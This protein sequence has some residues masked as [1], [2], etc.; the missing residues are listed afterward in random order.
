MQSVKEDTARTDDVHT[1][2]QVLGIAMREVRAV[3]YAVGV[4][5]IIAAAALVKG[6]YSS[7][8]EALL[9]GAAMLILMV[10]LLV[11]ERA[12]RVPPRFLQPHALVFTSAILT[13]FIVA[14]F[15]S[16]SIVFFEW[17]KRVSD[18]L[19]QIRGEN[20]VSVES[21]SD[22]SQVRKDADNAMKRKD[23]R[24]ALVLYRKL[25]DTGNSWAWFQLGWMYN[26]GFGVARDEAQALYWYRK[27]AAV[28]EPLGMTNLG[29]F[30]ERGLAVHKD[31]KQAVDW[32][33]KAAEV[34]EPW[35]MVNLGR[36]YENGLG[37]EKNNAKAADW[38]GKAAEAGHSRGMENIGRMYEHGLGVQRNPEQALYWYRRAAEAGNE[39]V[40]QNLTH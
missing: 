7:T 13:F 22:P 25:A 20:P 38:Y 2:S 18:L 11:F 14:C 4:A 3:R 24:V 32:Y 21:A 36:M 29:V 19:A 10:L 33:R 27:A 40:R 35:G 39:Q 5:G 12:T 16:L 26:N 9:V 17:P 8:G 6:F 28:G 30:Y 37:V 23:Y 15:L 31:E 1:P 34:G